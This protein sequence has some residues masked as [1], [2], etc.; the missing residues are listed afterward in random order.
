MEN[1]NCETVTQIDGSGVNL[2]LTYKQQIELK[3]KE[4]Q[5]KPLSSDKIKK[6]KSNGLQFLEKIKVSKGKSMSRAETLLLKTLYQS[7]GNNIETRIEI[8]D[9]LLTCKI[10]EN[11]AEII[12]DKICKYDDADKILY[13]FKNRTISID[14]IKSNKFHIV[15]ALSKKGFNPHLTLWLLDY[16]WNTTPSIGKG[17]VALSLILKNAKLAKTGDIEINGKV[18]EIKGLSAR[19]AGQSGFGNHSEIKK[20][21]VESFQNIIDNYNLNFKFDHDIIDKHDNSFNLTKGN[22]RIEILSKD[23]IKLGVNRIDI[24]KAVAKGIKA[25][26]KNIDLEE[27]TTWVSIFIN[28]KTGVFDKKG[29][30]RQFAI[31]G[32]NYYAEEEAFDTMICYNDHNGEVMA[33]DADSFAD[34]LDE[35]IVISMGGYGSHGG[36]QGPHHSITLK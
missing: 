2:K 8:F 24:A 36:S 7:L 34:Y 16:A 13:Y 12:S 11:A 29:F 10:P 5:A 3:H 27:T 20:A 9:Y 25:K 14:D 22:W 4:N 23:L 26:Y 1:Q 35:D 33:I 32:F 21:W 31:A 15:K 28:K 18:I 30:L 17:E 19:L 6:V